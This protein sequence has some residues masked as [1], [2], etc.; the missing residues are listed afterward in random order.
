MEQ[1]ANQLN[2][3][4]QM[5]EQ[6][7]NEMLELKASLD[8]IGK[9]ENK[10]IL[11]NIGKKIFIPVEIKTKELI[12]EVG[13]GHY[14]KKTPEE[15]IKIVESQLD[16]LMEGKTQIVGRLDELQNEMQSL[17]KEIEKEQA[18]A[19]NEKTN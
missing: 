1:E 10:D 16:R 4:L 5:V 2:E 18:V 9:E 7:V 19:G 3:Q 15:T 12:V 14:V 11:A 8:E 6:N 17:I 13:K